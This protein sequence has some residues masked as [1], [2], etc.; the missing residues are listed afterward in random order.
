MSNSGEPR[1]RRSHQ[2]GGANV[3]NCTFIPVT[4]FAQD[5]TIPADGLG[6]ASFT[7]E[8]VGGTVFAYV[9]DQ[10][11]D[12]VWVIDLAD[13]TVVTKIT[14]GAQPVGMAITPDGARAYVVNEFSTNVSVINLANNT[15]IGPPITVGAQPFGIAITPDGARAYVTNQGSDNVSVIN[16]ADNVVT[17][18]PVGPNPRGIA[19]TP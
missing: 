2:R 14:V 18:I 5:V 10:F 4:S 11:N 12:N 7:V 9:A 16:L 6:S 19:I 8:C 3:D 17:T 15:L 13:N 1:S